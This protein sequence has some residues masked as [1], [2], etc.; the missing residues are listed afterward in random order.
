MA[1]NNFTE[2]SKTELIKEVKKLRKR[3]KYGVL[4]EDKSE[5]VA[6]LC[7]EKLP[8]HHLYPTS[9]DGY[10]RFKFLINFHMGHNR[11]SNFNHDWEYHCA[12]V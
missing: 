5:K 2:W 11:S 4:W 10:Y 12:C 7:K 1:Q 8:Y 9:C 6:E 3:K